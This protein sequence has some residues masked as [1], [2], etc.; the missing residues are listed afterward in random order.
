MAKVRNADKGRTDASSMNPQ[1]ADVEKVNGLET[2]YSRTLRGDGVELFVDKNGNPT[3]S[4]PHVHVIHHGDG[5]V[6]V[7]AS[8]E[9]GKHVWR[10]ELRNPSGNEVNNAVA[11]ARSYL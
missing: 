10:H 9:P 6:N 2:F 11:T 8:K 4:Y 7:V 3:T 5:R 1:E